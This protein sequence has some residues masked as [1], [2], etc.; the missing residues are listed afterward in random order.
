MMAELPGMKSVVAGLIYGEMGPAQRFRSEKAYAKATGITPGKRESGGK[1]Q[2]MCISREGSRLARWALT[3][4]VL[5]CMRCRRG[6][7]AQVKTWVA[8]QVA[9][10]KP[11]RKVIVAAARKLAEGVWRLAKWGETFDLKRAFPT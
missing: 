10:H 2:L 3:R 9:R 7:G 1:V 6:V 4:A 11:K 5:A 8:K